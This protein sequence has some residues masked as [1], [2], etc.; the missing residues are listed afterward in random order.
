MVTGRHREKPPPVITAGE[1]GQ[2]AWCP[3]CLLPT[4]LR[5]PLFAD[6][7][8]CGGLE[9]CPGCGTGHDKPGAYITP[10]APQDRIIARDVTQAQRRSLLQVLGR[11]RDGPDCAWG[12]C[13]RRGSRKLEYAIPADEGTYRY[14]FCRTA[15]RDAWCETNG[16]LPQG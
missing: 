13:R 10:A 15:H 14:W 3:V 16:L 2:G 12:D 4:R 1:P 9:I 8:A 7:K 6:G 11:H 5:V